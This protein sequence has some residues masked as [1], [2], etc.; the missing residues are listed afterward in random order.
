MPQA[1]ITDQ[2][3]IGPVR[4]FIEKTTETFTGT[5]VFGDDGTAHVE[6]LPGVKK[7]IGSDKDVE[8]NWDELV[9]DRI[10]YVSEEEAKAYFPHNYQEIYYEKGMGWQFSLDVFHTLHCV[11]QIRLTLRNKNEDPQSFHNYHI[12]HCLEIIRQA[13]QCH[14]D[15]TPIPGHEIRGSSQ[16]NVSFN[17]F[18]D[19]DQ[20]H[21]CRNIWTLRKF[22]DERK[23]MDDARRKNLVDGERG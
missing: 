14:A 23:K 2:S 7:Y 20:T 16:R 19:S 21:T 15:L 22:L 5:P 10:F 4:D 3:S 12:E 17:H 8:A 11:N 9:R 13:I 18:F 1:T 6:R